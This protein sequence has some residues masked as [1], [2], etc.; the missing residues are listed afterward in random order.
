M[1]KKFISI[2]ND[3]R[4]I[5][6][7][8]KHYCRFSRSYFL[9]SILVSVIV[10]PL[11]AV[12]QLYFERELIDR[13]LAGEV[14]SSIALLIA[15]FVLV[16]MTLTV[17]N[18]LYEIYGHPKEMKIE[19]KINKTIFMQSIKT[20]LRFINDPAFYDD[21]NWTLSHFYQ[22]AK[23]AK[24]IVIRFATELTAISALLTFIAVLD[25]FLIVVIIAAVMITVIIQRFHVII[26]FRTADESR[27]PLRLIEYTK[28]IFCDPQNMAELKTCRSSDYLL[29]KYDEAADSRLKVYL[30]YAASNFLR[31]SS[32]S[33]TYYAYYAVAVMY[34]AY[35]ISGGYLTVGSFVA[36]I[37]AAH[38]VKDRM[39]NFFQ[40]FN[41]LHET[42]S[43]ARRSRSFLE[44]EPLIESD[45]TDGHK[46]E[47]LQGDAFSVELKNVSFGYD[48]NKPLLR[49]I[50]M[51]ISKGEKIA[52][53][54]EN[55]V[56]KSTFAKL[57]LRLY[58]VD[59]GK[60]LINGKEIDSYNISEL[61]QNVGIAFQKPFIYALSLA[62]N[63]Q[64]YQDADDKTLE[65]AL[66]QVGLDDLL[67]GTSK[68]LNTE[69]TKEFAGDGIM[70][71]GGQEQKLALARL[72][73]GKFGVMI[74]D[75]PS[76]ALD[77]IAEQELANLILG[78]SRETTTIIISHRLSTIKN[79]DKIYLFGDGGVLESGNHDSLMHLNGKYA[80]MF[81]VQAE[82]YV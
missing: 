27:L 41:E 4:N 17:S 42:A 16:V 29:K 15:L 19:Y 48:E 60:V 33:V 22:T 34:L 7:L 36:L 59:T 57:L 31:S 24:N 78:M 77:P 76:S 51:Y 2:R 10:H 52:I 25:S 37:A 23:S 75:E 62:E 8:V 81:N 72:L 49:N 74:L 46:R 43:L 80:E 5:V 58:D 47:G 54:G 30:K 66:R 63:L 79:V 32:F 39:T 82:G 45:K 40:I 14:L 61:R 28:R 64:L 3:F 73:V 67:T 38:Q 13:L 26:R 68:G 12:S 69:M 71:S 70:L 20:D 65:D 11:Y 1:T 6:F 50:N 21:Y 53:V 9:V 55:G 18:Y 35:R 44:A 56:G